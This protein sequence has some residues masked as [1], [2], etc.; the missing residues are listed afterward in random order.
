[1][2]YINLLSRL[3]SGS[4][5]D[6][7]DTDSYSFSPLTNDYTTISGTNN[8]NASVLNLLQNALTDQKKQ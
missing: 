6:S 5:S 8:Y 3:G 2:D 7:S 4:S 1:N